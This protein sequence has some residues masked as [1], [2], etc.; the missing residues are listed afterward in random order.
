MDLTRYIDESTTTAVKQGDIEGL[1][2]TGLTARAVTLLD[3]YVRK[4]SDLQTA[5]LAIS[6][7]SPLFLTNPLVESWRAAYR[8]WMNSWRMYTQRARFDV[9]STKL[10]TPAN[11]KSLL[12]QSQRQCSL[13]CTSCEQ[14]LDRNT[15]DVSALTDNDS[16][17]S[18]FGSHAG[19]IFGDT[20]FG[21]V[22]PKC[23]KHM[24]RCE[25]CQHWLGMPDHETKYG[26]ALAKTREQ[27]FGLMTTFCQKCLHMTHVAHAEMWFADH[28]VCPKVDCNCPCWE[29]MA[30]FG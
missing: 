19:S 10:S 6:H 5:V 14:A 29:G 16:I 20:K 15:R 4:F 12:K 13:A 3:A 17:A 25:V 30:G 21:T 23:G 26:K 9:D 27:L 7:T 2:L 8:S 28:Q 11:G 24:P 18:S 22:C 1:I